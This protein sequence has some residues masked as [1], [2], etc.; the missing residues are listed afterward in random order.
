MSDIVAV[1]GTGECRVGLWSVKAGSVVWIEPVVHVVLVLFLLQQVQNESKAMRLYEAKAGCL[2]W[3]L[4]KAN[5]VQRFIHLW[6]WTVYLFRVI[7]DYHDSNIF[8]LWLNADEESSVSTVQLSTC[9]VHLYEQHLSSWISELQRDASLRPMK[10]R[11][12]FLGFCT[13]S[14]RCTGAKV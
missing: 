4:S 11:L 14:S 9:H 3:V 6:N 8:L 1:T 2:L 7:S 13:Q 10:G 12:K 5:T